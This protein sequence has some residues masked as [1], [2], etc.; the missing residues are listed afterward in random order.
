MN[1]DAQDLD[2]FINKMKGLKFSKE[3]GE[4]DEQ[5]SEQSSSSDEEEFIKVVK[6][7]KK[8]VLGEDVMED[9]EVLDEEKEDEEVTLGKEEET[10][11]EKKK[12]KDVMSESKNTKKTTS[13]T[14]S[15]KA[16]A[17][18]H[19]DTIIEEQ[20]VFCSHCGI[21]I[22][23]DTSK[24]SYSGGRSLQ[25]R[26]QT[27]SLYN[28]VR[29]MNFSDEIKNKANAIFVEFI[30]ES[31]SSTNICRGD[32]RKA[33]IFACIKHAYAQRGEIRTFK[34]LNGYFQ[35][36]Q[37]T[38]SKVNSTLSKTLNLIRKSPVNWMTP[39][40]YIKEIMKNFTSSEEMIQE[41]VDIYNQVQEKISKGSQSYDINR[42]RPSSVASGV[43]YYWIRNNPV[44]REEISLATL[45]EKIGISSN[46]ISKK[47]K[48]I[49]LVLGSDLV[50]L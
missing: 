44:V 18:R 35:I 27:K 10:M 29:D 1:K 22:E 14:S 41:V 4:E 24:M 13:P 42:S 37:K 39:D 23:K 25:R 16:V 8:R 12:E 36:S 9:K 28:D 33:L 2:S 15:K 30:T 19:K 11:S 40:I 20:T 38:F 7:S 46:T 47:C 50:L 48:E 5:S 34:D 3:F 6:S 49:A 26:D 21:E 45:S 31:D 32:K 17:C 43:V